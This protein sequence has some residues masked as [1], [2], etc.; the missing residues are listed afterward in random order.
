MTFTTIFAAFLIALFAVSYFTKRRFGVLGLAL[1]AGAVISQYWASTLT[2]LIKDQGIY[3][4]NPPLAHLVAAALVLLPAVLLLFSGPT[5]SQKIQRIIGSALFAFLAVAFLLD[6]LGGSLELDKNSLAVYEFID[7]FKPTIIV[8]GLAAAIG[9]VLM[10]H[11][12][13]RRRRKSE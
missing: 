4:V 5:Y 6:I 11:T 8:V 2:P 10:T 7:R 13:R 3:L 9:D 12:P 1:A